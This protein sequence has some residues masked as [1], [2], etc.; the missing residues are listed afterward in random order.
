VAYQNLTEIPL[1]DISNTDVLM[2]MVGGKPVW[3]D[4]AF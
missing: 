1:D 4:P 2:T 3:A